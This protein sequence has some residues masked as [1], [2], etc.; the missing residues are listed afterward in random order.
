[1]RL[2]KAIES[3]VEQTEA[4]LRGDS[5]VVRAGA[6][7]RLLTRSLLKSSAIQCESHVRENRKVYALLQEYGWVETQSKDG[8]HLDPILNMS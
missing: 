6:V 2:V 4:S 3:R 1:M 5:D 8:S 7:P